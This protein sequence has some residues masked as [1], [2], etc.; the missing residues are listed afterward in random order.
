[1]IS[2]INNAQR[3]RIVGR[4]LVIHPLETKKSGFYTGFTPES[5]K[6]RGI[7]SLQRKVFE[8]TGTYPLQENRVFRLFKVYILAIKS[9][10]LIILL[11]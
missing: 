3:S 10:N 7:G 8:G 5:H 6:K 9:H 4:I 2:G 11:S 1:M